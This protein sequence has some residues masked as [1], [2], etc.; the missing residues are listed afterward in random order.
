MLCSEKSVSKSVPLM[1]GFYIL[2]STCKK[3]QKIN[4]IGY[5]VK[6]AISKMKKWFDQIPSYNEE[7]HI[8]RFAD[9]LSTNYTNCHK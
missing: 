9:D 8:E 1:H 3:A 6:R 2:K 4:R 5:A 7:E